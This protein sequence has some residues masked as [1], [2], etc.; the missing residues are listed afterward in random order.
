MSYVLLGCNEILTCSNKFILTVADISVMTQ[1]KDFS[2]HF[3]LLHSF[4]IILLAIFFTF[5]VNTDY[6][7]GSLLVVG[8]IEF[9]ICKKLIKVM[10]L[11]FTQLYPNHAISSKFVF[12]MMLLPPLYIIFCFKLF[13]KNKPSNSTK[14]PIITQNKFIN[15]LL[16]A[17]IVI[18]Y[19][20]IPKTIFLTGSPSVYYLTNLIR[21]VE[22]SLKLINDS[23][24]AEVYQSTFDTYLTN[25]NQAPTSTELIIIMTLSAI[26]ISKHQMKDKIAHESLIRLLSEFKKFLDYGHRKKINFSDYSLI[27]WLAPAGLVEIAFI[28]A[29]ENEL[30]KKSNL[31]FLNYAEEILEQIK[32]SPKQIPLE[33]QE[34]IKNFENSFSKF[35]GL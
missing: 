32:K 10:K 18:Q 2:K 23:S 25:Y 22:L 31:Y 19:A 13:V 5:L 11:R 21:N 3:I 15:L 35:K 33:Y 14:P 7:I 1:H 9:F 26:V 20:F 16:I 17:I 30:N 6:W 4:Q 24:K 28:S 34:Q 29:L 27:Q 12:L 8:F